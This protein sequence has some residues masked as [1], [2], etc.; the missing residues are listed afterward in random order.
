MGKGKEGLQVKNMCVQ[1]MLG[2]FCCASTQVTY[3][4]G[5]CC[6]QAFG[7]PCAHQNDNQSQANG[8]ASALQKSY[9]RTCAAVTKP[10][11]RE[12]S[13]QGSRYQLA[14]NPTRNTNG[15]GNAPYLAHAFNTRGKQKINTIRESTSSVEAGLSR[16]CAYACVCLSGE[17]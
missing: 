10:A 16:S 13:T 14:V 7:C 11:P 2:R 5:R 4:R 12:K 6:V 8:G 1:G 9:V 17:S 3:Q 15:G